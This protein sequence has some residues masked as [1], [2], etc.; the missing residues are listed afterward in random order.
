MNNL[1]LKIANVDGESK[2][3]NHAG[4]IDV[5]SVNWGTAR[6]SNGV[7][8]VHYRNLVVH[9]VL[10]KA[11]PTLLLYSSNAKKIKAVEVSGCKAGG[12]QIEFYRITLEN[13]VVVEVSISDSGFESD[14]VYEFQADKVK[15]QYWEQSSLGGKAAE[16]RGGWDIKNNTSAF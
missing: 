10:D 6:N 9:A 8:T 5:H 15:M 3:V 12:T 13:V 2:D 7:G 11:A 4:W 16:T 1:F 14:A